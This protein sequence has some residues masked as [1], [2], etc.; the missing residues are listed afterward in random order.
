MRYAPI[1]R[2]F[3]AWL[4]DLVV[5]W[6]VFKLL[7]IV[8]LPLLEQALTDNSATTAGDDGSMAFKLSYE[9][10][11]VA[12]APAI[13][14]IWLYSALLES[15]RFQGTVGKI[16]LSLRVTHVDGSR[17]TFLRATG[18]IFA[19]LLSGFIFML[20]YIVALFTER[21]QALHDLM[22]RTVVVA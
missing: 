7:T 5:L 11:L 1:G 18:R 17:L 6:V 22:A 13:A 10:D 8:G 4:I 20:G 21:K 2:R 15:S 9:F 16:V 12:G 3:G 19:K 14:L